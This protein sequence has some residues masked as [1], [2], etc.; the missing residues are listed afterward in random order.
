[1]YRYEHQDSGHG[2]LVHDVA[3]NKFGTRMAT[4][5][6]YHTVR[7]WDKRQDKENKA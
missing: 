6:S 2:E 5:S 1:M 3:F 4:C 7:V